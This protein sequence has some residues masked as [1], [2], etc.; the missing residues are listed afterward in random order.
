MTVDA[1]PE[2]TFAYDIHG[3]TF[4]LQN[5]IVKDRNGNEVSGDYTIADTLGSTALT[6][7]ISGNPTTY[8][9]TAPSG[10]QVSVNIHYQTFTVRTNFGCNGVT[11]VNAHLELTP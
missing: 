6:I 3:D 2:A 10:Q 7:S 11:D 1:S 8:T 4:D 9:Y 5:S